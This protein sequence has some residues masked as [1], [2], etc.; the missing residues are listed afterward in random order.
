MFVSVRGRQ[1]EGNTDQE[2]ETGKQMG[3]RKRDRK[4]KIC[5]PEKYL[6]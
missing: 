3:D 5:V 1:Q 2:T 4:K 6:F